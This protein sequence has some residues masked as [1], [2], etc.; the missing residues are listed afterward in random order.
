MR[1]EVIRLFKETSLTQKEISTLVGFT[2]DQI[3][4]IVN[5]EFTISFRKQRKIKCYSNSK[6]GDKNPMF[7][8]KPVN[9]M[10]RVSDGNGYMMVLKPGWYTGRKGCM[11]VFEHHIV[12]CESL[13]ITEIPSGFHVHHI[14]KDKVNNAINNLALLTAEAHRRL[15][16]LERATTREKSRRD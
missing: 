15:H 1:D 6:L 2:L 8:K 7:G 9:Y 16:Q 5:K 14:D 3:Y 13:G 12:I 4:T 10:G 11:H